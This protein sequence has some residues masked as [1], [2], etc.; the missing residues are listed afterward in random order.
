MASPP[1]ASCRPAP[2]P[3][4]LAIAQALALS[5]W[6]AHPSRVGAARDR[7]AKKG[8]LDADLWIVAPPTPALALKRG[9]GA[10]RQPPRGSDSLDI[11]MSEAGILVTSRHPGAK[12][13]RRHVAPND[14]QAGLAAATQPLIGSG[15]PARTRTL[16]NP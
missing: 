3:A 1:G 6:P 9:D 12:R 13:K 11:G 14:K 8:F 5:S 4:A 10:R 2:T 16:E 7:M 15:R